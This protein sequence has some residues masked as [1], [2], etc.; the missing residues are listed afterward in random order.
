[1]LKK[2]DIKI[3]F[4]SK[5]KIIKKIKA[6]LSLA[7]RRDTIIFFL[8]MLVA[9]LLETF[10]IGLIVP[11]IKVLSDPEVISSTN[12]LSGAINFLGI[13][14]YR[15][16]VISVSVALVLAFLIKNLYLAFFIWFKVRFI[17]NLRMNLSNRLFQTY[18][19]QPYT[20]HLQRNS[21][22]L[23][24]NISTEVLIFTGRLLTPMAV[25]M[26]ELLVLIGLVILL[27]IV[28]PAG[29][30]IIMTTFS[31]IGWLIISLTRPHIKRWGKLRQF[32]DGKRI[33]H[34]QQ[35]LGGVKVA[36]MLQKTDYFLGQY[37]Y[38]NSQSTYAGKRQG[39]FSE[40]LRT[41]FEVLAVIGV[42]IMILLLTIQ[43]HKVS[44]V[45]VV[46][47]VFAAAAFRIMPSV[48]R[49]IAA[50]QS[51]RY[52]MP[53]LNRLHEEFKIKE[54][55][56]Y[57]AS[58]KDDKKKRSN[59]SDKLIF[60]NVS[61]SYPETNKPSLNDVT[62]KI[63]HGECIGIIGSSGAGKTTLVDILLGL[64]QPD[65]GKISIDGNDISDSVSNWQ[66]Q[67]GYVPE[68]IF[69][70]DDSLR[71]N[72]A[73]GIPDNEI[74]DDLIEKA[75]RSAQLEDFVKTLPDGVNTF[76]GER[77]IR[78]SGGQRQRIGIA[79][80]LY[81]D[82]K[83]L[84]FDEA[85]SALDNSTEREIMKTVHLMHQY[86]TIIIIAHRLST[87]E[88]CDRLYVLDFGK[89]IDEGIPSDLLPQ[90]K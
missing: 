70:I 26:S 39:F 41:W 79:R 8:L 66:R 13:E 5:L 46:L 54:S 48:T 29:A 83:V 22:Q 25:L 36:L 16:L 43:D 80:A 33:Q 60:N 20:F 86:K 17:S 45:F 90:R 7:E 50:I 67:I 42:A 32:H 24:Q 12:Y 38:H 6:L 81:H 78:I 63:K 34:L 47:G 52:S 58:F 1:M 55:S 57:R 18:L 88:K 21:G 30:L 56:Y 89:I 2:V 71:K 68:S 51:I 74:N 37:Q 35:G 85:T 28:E 27:L 62:I 4:S 44:T 61:F 53:V 87:V 19:S 49:I 84:V 75:I 82:P 59:F 31:I 40:I 65:S 73:F 14:N 69:L 15:L 11:L 64:I 3:F 76:V 9:M 77:G 72:I 23:L 10:S